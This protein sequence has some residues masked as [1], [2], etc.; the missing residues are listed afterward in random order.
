MEIAA[1]KAHGDKNELS[2]L[3]W[4]ADPLL[5]FDISRELLE[6]RNKDSWDRETGRS[7]KTLAK[8]SD[9]RVV[10]VLMKANTQ[11]NQHQAEGR[12]SIQPI[13]GRMLVRLP[14][15]EVTLSTGELLVLDGDVLHDIEAK[16]ESAFLLTISWRNDTKHGRE[17]SE[18]R[19][20]RTF[21]EDALL[22]MED[23]GAGS[24]TPK[25]T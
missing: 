11:M 23:E 25:W 16:E 1:C 21:D 5:K 20:E 4:L 17:P 19:K 13:S 8:H 18:A 3:P 15:Q 22:R 7:S 6:L 24:K 9:F 12:I 10:L 14:H 2:R